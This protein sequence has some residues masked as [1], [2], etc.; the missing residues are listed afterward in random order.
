M[1]NR[2]GDHHEK[3]NDGLREAIKITVFYFF[4]NWG[5]EGQG[6]RKLSRMIFFI[7][8]TPTPPYCFETL[9]PKLVWG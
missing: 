7:V 8:Q 9:S 5:V 6:V 1:E 3:K 2:D 4:L